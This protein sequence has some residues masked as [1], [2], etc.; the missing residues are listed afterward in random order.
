MTEIPDVCLK[1]GIMF[2]GGATGLTIFMTSFV[3]DTG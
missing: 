3:A 2:G 1:F